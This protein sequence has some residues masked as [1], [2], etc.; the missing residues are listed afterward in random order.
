[1]M[2]KYWQ[3]FQYYEDKPKEKRLVYT[4]DNENSAHDMVEFIL[5]NDFM[6]TDL[7]VEECEVTA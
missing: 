7:K 2:Y 4:F 5:K 3:V 6:P 1:M